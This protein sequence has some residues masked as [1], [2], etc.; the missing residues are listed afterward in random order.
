MYS[1]GLFW[2]HSVFTKT[3]QP[4]G[5]LEWCMTSPWHHMGLW[6]FSAFSGFPCTVSLHHFSRPDLSHSSAQQGTCTN[7]KHTPTLLLPS[8]KNPMWWEGQRIP[9]SRVL[10]LVVYGEQT[11]LLLNTVMRCV[12]SHGTSACCRTTHHRLN[13]KGRE[14]RFTFKIFS[15]NEN[16]VKRETKQFSQFRN[17]NSKLHCKW[18]QS[19]LYRNTALKVWFQ[20][21]GEILRSQQ[22]NK[23][24]SS[25]TF[26]SFKY[27]Y[28][29]FIMH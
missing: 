23:H 29:N 1:P 19:E 20:K 27:I 11:N 24:N 26:S 18:N 12:H 28:M 25:N 15:Y 22:Q 4:R 14:N 21:W 2:E 6:S 3:G 16:M 5:R 10:L 9:G 13:P 7:R 17:Q 8:L